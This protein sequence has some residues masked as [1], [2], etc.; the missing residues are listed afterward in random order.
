M[1]SFTCVQ[2]QGH[3]ISLRQLPVSDLV[4]KELGNGHFIVTTYKKLNKL[5]TYNS[6]FISIRKSE[7]IGSCFVPRPG[8]ADNH[9]LQSRNLRAGTSEGTSTGVGKPTVIGEL[10]SESQCEV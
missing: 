3:Q 4:C 7:V 9:N 5:K 6:P 1:D 10:V 2:A 8:E